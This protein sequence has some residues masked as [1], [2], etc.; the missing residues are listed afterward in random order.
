MLIV[1]KAFESGRLEQ[2][3]GLAGLTR[4]GVITELIFKTVAVGEI[5]KEVIK[6]KE[7]REP[8]TEPR[9]TPTL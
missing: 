5:A 3:R 4:L 7:R 1:G 6:P 8:R 2:G 9:L